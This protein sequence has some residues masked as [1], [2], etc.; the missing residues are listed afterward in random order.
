MIIGP[1]AMHPGVIWVN[2]ITAPAVMQQ[3]DRTIL[4][5]IHIYHNAITKKEM[6][7]E[8]RD[9]G[10]RSRGYF[11]REQ[12]D[13]LRDAEMHGTTVV[14]Q[15][16]GVSYNMIVKAGGVQALPKKEVETIDNADPYTGTITFQEI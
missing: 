2:E 1:H 10:N 12:I 7:V 14:V 15:Y 8:A 11:T 16:R 13:Y 9:G 5:N 3:I 6:I 4:N